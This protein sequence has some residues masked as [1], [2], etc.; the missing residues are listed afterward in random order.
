M[1]IN[2]LLNGMILQVSFPKTATPKHQTFATANNFTGHI[3][4]LLTVLRETWLACGGPGE[5]LEIY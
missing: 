1:V 2:H 4:T 3:W 5:G